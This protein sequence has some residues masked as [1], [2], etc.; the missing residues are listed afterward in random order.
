MY[1]HRSVYNASTNTQG[2]PLYIGMA[3]KKNV[4]ACCTVRMQPPLG[5]KAASGLSSLPLGARSRTRLPG[6]AA[7]ASSTRARERE[8]ARHPRAH[9]RE[10]V[11]DARAPV[12]GVLLLLLLLLLRWRRVCAATRYC[13]RGGWERHFSSA[14]V[15]VSMCVYVWGGGYI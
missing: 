9:V 8:R 15:G 12:V 5:A 7:A 14:P 2:D 1:T 13:T 3:K 10:R 6:A 11:E 4:L